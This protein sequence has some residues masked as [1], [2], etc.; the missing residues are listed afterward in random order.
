[1][2]I[3][4]FRSRPPCLVIWVNFDFPLWPVRLF[5]KIGKKGK[6][7]NYYMYLIGVGTGGGGLKKDLAL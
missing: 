1:M 6:I 3:F 7:S 5:Q 2:I 4:L